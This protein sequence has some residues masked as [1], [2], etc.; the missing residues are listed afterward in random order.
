MNDLKIEPEYQAA[1][2]TWAADPTPEAN[3]QILKDLD[4]MIDKAIRTHV[5]TNNPLYRSRA[6]QMALSGLRT[7]D[8]TR[9]RLQSHLYSQLQGL[10]RYAGQQQNILKVPER[11]L[12]DRRT[13]QAAQTELE[14]RLGRE[15]T[16][17]ELGRE[18]GFSVRRLARIRSF[19]PATSEGFLDS[20]AQAGEGGG[21]NPAVET[22]SDMW[23]RMVYDDLGAIDKKVM[24][25][26]LGLNGRQPLSTQEIARR[27]SITPGAVSQR[28]L[29]IQQLL[30]QGQELMI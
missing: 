18:T 20:V 17:E 14:D 29:K 26:G 25:W 23:T 13:L 10:K 12:L 2:D 9:G 8:P 6:R 22:E 11:V 15:P 1:Y 19:N 4:P 3:A 16:D 27:L 7:Y 24:E 21:L 30:D 28:K 5:G